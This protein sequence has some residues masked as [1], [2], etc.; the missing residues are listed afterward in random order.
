M[1]VCKISSA[2]IQVLS[3]YMP[4]LQ[5]QIFFERY[6][7]SIKKKLSELTPEDLSRFVLYVAKERDA[8]NISDEKF[9]TLLR[10]LTMLSNE[11]NKHVNANVEKKKGV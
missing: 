3:R 1:M 4:P 2:T 10:E 6:S 8:F 7:K 11:E 5:A 9:S